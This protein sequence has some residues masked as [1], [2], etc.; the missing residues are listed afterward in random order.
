VSAARGVCLN[1][2]SYRPKNDKPSLGAVVVPLP[3]AY[4]RLV[5]LEYDLYLAAHVGPGRPIN[6]GRFLSEILQGELEKRFEQATG[7]RW[8]AYLA[9]VAAGAKFE[10]VKIAAGT[11]VLREEREVIQ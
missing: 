1:R 10:V 5:D 8:G 11:S 6:R 3:E 4:E 2:V 9:R 7:M